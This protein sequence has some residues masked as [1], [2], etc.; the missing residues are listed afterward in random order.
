MSLRA[1]SHPMR[2]A[3]TLL[4][5]LTTMAIIAILAVLLLPALQSGYGKAK[6]VAC[7]SRLMQ[8]GVAF[9]SW[10]H[11]HN[12][13]FPMQVSTNQQG[14][15]E[16]AQAAALNPDVSFT[17]RHFQ[18][19]S[20]ELMVAKVL[21][22]P[23]DR[24]RFA[25][26]DFGSLSNANVSYWINSASVPGHPDS[27]LAG[28]R[29]VRTSGRTEWTFVQFGPGDKLEF[30]AELHGY[31]G[32]VLFGDAHIEILDSRALRAAFVFSNSP[33][34]TLS[35]PQGDSGSGAATASATSSA[36]SSGSGDS[37]PQQSGGG[38]DGN[39]DAAK[40]SG[41]QSTAAAGQASGGGNSNSSAPTQLPKPSR[42][43]TAGS[44][45]EENRFVVTRL[46]GTSVTSSAPKK[47]TNALA[48]SARAVSRETNV[49]NPLVEFIEWL[50][51]AASRAT[52]W[53]L[54]LLLLAL[55]AFDLARRRAKRQPGKTDE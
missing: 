6:R 45:N 1:Q 50:G 33:E 49:G 46:D 25:A 21:V 44:G 43:A 23:A 4:E 42:G 2:R 32:N 10:A 17:F 15:L 22:C 48:S 7:T 19:V 26:N 18:A 8:I 40:S 16:F 47:V 20:N 55:I 13:L 12:D 14:T 41:A 30:S 28:D 39:A 3:F 36:A 29:N 9:H 27:P 54:L 31:R 52:Y 37:S 24:H 51:H 11:D 38:S 5:L 34:V 35:L 53:L